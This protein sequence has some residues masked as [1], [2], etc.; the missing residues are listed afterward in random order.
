VQTRS[1]SW[2]PPGGRPESDVVADNGAEHRHPAAG[3]KVFEQDEP[4]YRQIAVVLEE[5]LQV[6]ETP[7]AACWILAERN[8]CRA[9]IALLAC[10]RGKRTQQ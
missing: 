7:E 8:R 1:T 6:P 3:T 10:R 5:G 4:A 9:A 2:Q